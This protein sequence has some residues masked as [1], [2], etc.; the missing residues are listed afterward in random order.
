VNEPSSQKVIGSKKGCT[1]LQHFGL[2]DVQLRGADLRDVR[3]QT[4]VDAA[5]LD[6]NEHSEIH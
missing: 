2:E 4:A 6:A 3:A 1:H 5:A